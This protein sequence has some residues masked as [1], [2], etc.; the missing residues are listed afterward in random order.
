MFMKS[1]RKNEEDVL[2]LS[3]VLSVSRKWERGSCICIYYFETESRECK[4]IRHRLLNRVVR[5]KYQEENNTELERRES[6]TKKMLEPFRSGGA[7]QH[8]LR[9][10][11]QQALAPAASRAWTESQRRGFAIMRPSEPRRPGFSGGGGGG[12][13]GGFGGGPPV[14]RV[15]RRDTPFRVPRPRRPYGADQHKDYL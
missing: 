11:P 10:V 9:R 4:P 15:E 12:G 7:L 1:I 5:E 13:G 6:K 14:Y 3:D 8:A 2:I